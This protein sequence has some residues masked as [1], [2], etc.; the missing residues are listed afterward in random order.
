MEG[1]GMFLLV[2]GALLLAGMLLAPLLFV[3]WLLYLLV[4]IA[5]LPFRLAGAVLRLTFGLVGVLVGLVAAVVAEIAGGLVVGVLLLIPLLPF[6]ALGLGL[7]WL[8]R[9]TRPRPGLRSA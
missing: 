5:T 2:M 6:V 7:A 9:A 4:K 8:Y 1:V 3:F